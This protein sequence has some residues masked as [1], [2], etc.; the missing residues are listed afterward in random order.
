MFSLGLGFGKRF[1]SRAGL[2]FAALMCAMGP[3][4][5]GAQTAVNPASVT[6]P[7]T[8]VASV[9]APQIVTLTN[10]QATPLT[11]NAIAPSANFAVSGTTCPLSPNTLAA[12]LSCTISVTFS[13]V[14]TGY[15][16]GALTIT[17]DASN[18]PSTVPLS[19][20]GTSGG[21][22]SVTPGSLS[23]NATA[24]GQSFAASYV[25]FSNKQ[26]AAITVGPVQATGDFAVSNNTCP[27]SLSAAAS[28]KI[29]V[30]FTPTATGARAGTLSIADSVDT[31][32]VEVSLAGTG[33]APAT[34]APASLA[35]HS[36]V[37]SATS[38]VQYATVTNNQPGVLTI[39]QIAAPGGGF[40]VDSSACGSLP[41]S[42]APGHS[43]KIAVT[44][45]PAAIGNAAAT[46]GITES[47]T[48]TPLPVALS[49]TGVAAAAISPA[50]LNLGNVVTGTPSAIKTATL[51]NYQAVAMNIASIALPGGSAF[52]L[53]PSTTCPH[54][55]PLSAGASCTIAVTFTPPSTGAQSSTLTVTDD[56][57]NS[58]Q[59]LALSGAGILPATLS[60]SSVGFGSVAVGTT[61]AAKTVT[62]KNNSSSALSISSVLFGGPFALDASATSATTCPV[63]GGTLAAGATCVIGL[64]YSPVATGAN[65]GQITVIDSA[66]NSPQ[67]T[68]LTGTGV[69]AT[70][71]SP[72][73]VNF[74][75]VV[76][77][78]TSATKNV[79]LTNNQAVNLNLHTVAVT[80][81]YAVV[82]ATTTCMVG[83]PVGP[84]QS[85]TVSLNFTPTVLGGAPSSAL[86]IT[87][88]AATSPQ[89]VILTG[90]GASAVTLSPAPLNLGTV[91]VN[92]ATVKDVTLKNN[93]AVP[94]TIASITGFSGG[95]KLDSSS[96]CPLAPSALPAGASCVIAVSLTATATGANPGAITINDDAPGGSQSFNLSATSVAPVVVQ[97]PTLYF[98][99]QYLGTSSVASV[100]T[101][102]N[103][104]SVPLTISSVMVG[105]TNSGDFGVTT[106]CPLAP[107]SLPANSHCMLSV[108]FTPTGPGTRTAT[109]TIVD[110]APGSPRIV[111][112]T[113]PGSAPVVLSPTSITNFSAPV[114]TTSRYQTITVKNGDP[115]LPLHIS[116]FEF[117]GD[118]VQTSTTCPIGGGTALA[119]GASCNV[120]VSFAPSIGGVRTGQLQVNDDAV[121]SPQ[122][123]NLSGTGTSPLKLSTGAV[124]FSAQRVSTTSP[125]KTV[126]LTN[127]ESQQET[128]SLA[129]TGDFTASSNCTSG[130]IAAGSTCLLYVNFVPTATGPRYGSLTIAD[131]AAIGSPLT[132]S[133]S[134]SGT[135]TNPPGEVS[136]VSPGAGTAGTVVNAII[137]GNGWTN[138]GPTS[139]VSFDPP[140]GTIPSGITVTIPNPSTTT[141]NTINAQFTIAAGAIAGARNIRVVTGSKTALLV[142]AFIV[143]DTSNSHSIVTL[144]PSFG[145]Q[146]Q[147]LNVD[148]TAA[149]T[150]F[151]DGV[152]YA[153]FGDGITV[154]STTVTSPT[155]AQVNI[156]ISNT[157]FVGYRTVTLV[158]GGEFATSTPQGFLINPNSAALVSVA[159]NSAP[160]GTNLAV[161]LTASGTHFLQDAT[162]ASFGGGVLAGN[163]QVTSPTT[164]I[165]N[166]AVSSGAAVGLHDVQIATGGEMATLPN[167]FTVTGAT[168]YLAS[169]TPSSAQQGQTVTV[170]IKGVYTSF[171]ASNILADFGGD[172]TVNSTNVISPTEVQVKI[173][174]SQDAAVTGRTARLTSGPSGSATIFPF[175]FTVT[176]SAAQIVSVSPSNVAQGAQVTLNVVG[177]NTHWVQ[178]TTMAAFTPYPLGYIGVDEVTVT[179][180]THATLNIAVSTNHPVGE[181][182]FYMATGGEV[183]YASVS[184]Y[185]QTPTMT[186]SPAN[187]LPGASMSVS[188]TGQ[189]TNW[190]SNTLAVVG[191]QGVT[192]KNLVITSVASATGTLVIDPNA[193]PGSRT[194]TFTTGGEIDTTSFNVGSASLTNI[195]PSHAAQNTTLTVEITGS[196]TH[197]TS[198]VTVV[199]FDPFITVNGPPTVISPTDL[200]ANITVAANASAGWHTA[201]VNTGAEQLII[202]FLVDSPAMPMLV[203]V[204][205]ACGA[206][207]S[208]ESVTITGS[209]TNFVAGE[210]EAIL[211]AGVTV[212]D[213]NV[214]SPTV[215][216]ATISVSP[217][218]PIGGNSV[219]L[220]TGPEVISGTGFCVSPGAAEI[221]SVEPNVADI[222]AL[223]AGPFVVAQ[224]Q[225]AHLAF[226]GVGTHWLQGETI[227]D[228]GPGVHIDNLTVT[229]PTTA[230]VQ[231]TVLS[232]AQVGFAALTMTTDGEVVTLQQAIDIEQGYPTL[233]LTTPAGGEQGATLNLQLLGR[234]T[235]W[236]QGVTT[237]AF[238]QDI[239]V[240]S[241]TVIDSVSAIAN[242][243]VSPL[244]YID[245]VCSP[246]GH[247]IS[248]TTG[249]EQVSL[250]GTFCVSQGAAQVNQVSPSLAVQGSTQTVTITGSATHFIAGVTTA[251]F[252]PGINVGNVTVMS[253]TLATVSIAVT[254][255]APTGYTSVTLTTLGEV[256]T[257]QFAFQVS[258]GVATLNEAIPNQVEQGVQNVDVHLIGQY[259]HFSGLSTATFGEG[260]TV[261]SVSYTDAT[262]LTANVS[263][264][265]LSYTGS[266]TVTVTTPGVPCGDLFNVAATPPCAPGAT[267]GSEIVS[268]NA[269]TVIQGPAII[270]QVSPAGGNQGQ[271][272]V[273]Q[274]T[275]SNTHW[276]QNITQFYIPGAGSDL[277]I[278][279]VV[280]NSP[281]S[282]TVDL[283]ISPTAAPGARSIYMVTGGEALVDA[284]GFVLTGG[285]PAIAYLTPNKGQPGATTLDVTIHGIYTN[286]DSTSTVDFGPGITVATVQVEDST[287]INAVI[288]ISSGA[289]VGYRT[290]LVRTGAQGLT[291]NFLVYVPTPPVP[292][293]SYY[294]PSSGLT[295]Q[296]F[297]ISFT[298]SNTHWDPGPYNAATTATFGD[299]I[300]VNTFQVTS[301]TSALANITIDPSTYAGQRLIVFTTGAETES[302]TFNVSIPGVPGGAAPTLSIV[303]PSQGMQ[304]TASLNVNVIG[305]YTTF[306]NTTAFDFGQGITVNSVT[307]LGPTIASVNIS[308]DQLAQ[309]GG[310]SVTA[311]MGGQLVA[312]AGFSVTPS[313]ALISAIMP[314]TALQGSTITVEVTGQNTHWSSATTFQLGAG[315]VVASATVNSA[316]DATLVLSLPALAP[317]GPTYA[318]AQTLGEVANITH[319]FVVQAGTPLLLS[320]GP[321]S[322]PQQSSATF[323]I[324]SQATN[325]T[326]NPPTVD[327]GPG[328]TLTNTIVTGDTS[329]TVD[330]Y[331]Q[332][333]TTVGYRNLTVSTATQVLSLPNAV[334][335][336]AGPA[337]INTVSPST[338][339]Q[340][341]TVTVA[342]RGTNTHW[343]QGVTQLSFPGVVINSLTVTSATTA[344][345]SVTVSTSATPGLVNIITTT[346]LGEVATEVNAFEITQTQPEMLFIN[347]ASAML[348]QSETVTILTLNTHFGPTS[349]ASFGAGITVNSVAALTATSLQAN[350]TVQPTTVLGYR[351][352]SVTTGSEVV[353]STTLFQ[354]T[355][356]P[357]A[358]AS[359]S[360]ASGG[361]GRSVT[362]LVTG[363]QT[364]FASGVTS[365]SFGGGISVTGISVVDA[366]HANVTVSI[367]SSTPIASY[368]VTLTTGGEVATILGG[369]GVTLG[370]A[371]IATVTPAT[372]HQGDTNLSV[373]I[374]GQYTSF[375]NGSSSAS[376]GDGITVNSL[377]VSS[378]TTAVANI[379]ISPTA[380]LASRTVTVTTGPEV[381]SITG[382]FT[383]LAGLPRL[384]AV[385]PATGHQNDTNLSVSITGQFTNFVNGT[386][387]ANF[388]SG[389]TVNSLTVSSATAALANITI[390]PTATLASRT[391]T[392]TTGS[393]VAS[394]TSGFTV[395]AGLP[396]VSAVTPATGHQGDTSLS[397]SIT[398]QYTNFV[399]GTSAASFGSGITVNSFTVSSATSAVANITISDTAT[400]GLHTVTV[401]TGSE[402][403][404]NTGLFTVIVGL[405]TLAAVNPPTGNQGD[406]N[407]NVSI[408]GQFT[409]FVNGTSS[410]SFGAGITVN[411]LTVS[412][413]TAAVASITIS[414]TA[415][416]ASRTVTVTTG[417]EIAS[418]TGG[419]TVLAGTPSLVSA[420]PGSA[421]AGATTSVVIDGA[422][423]S[424]QQGVSTVSFGSGVTVNSVTVA[425]ATQLSVNVSVDP[426]AYTGA[427]D[428]TVT[429]D[430]QTVTLS[431][432][433]TVLPG[434]AV[435]T[436]INSNIGTPNSTV[437]VTINGQYTNW[438]SATTAS[439]G[440]GISVGGAAEGVSGPVTVNSA[441]SLTAT[442]NIDADADLGP[443]DVI[444]TTGTEIETV[445]AGFTVQPTTVSPPTVVSTS[446]GY[447]GT[448]PIN[449]SIYLVFS[450][451]MDRS[452]ITAANVLLYLNSS[453]GQYGNI[454]VAGSVSLD[455]AGRMLTFTPTS[456]L[457]VNTQYYFELT[458]GVKDASGN[459]LGYYYTYF[460]TA[461]STT[462]KPPTVIAANPP[463]SSPTVGTNTTIQ[464]QFSAP[465]DQ[466]TQT[467][468][469]LSDGSSN[470]AGTF[471][472]N[473][474]SNCSYN[475]AY[476]SYQCASG[477]IVTFTPA[478]PLTANH[479]YTVN[480]GAPL[481]DTA[482]NTLASGSFS[483][484]TGSGADTTNNS[485][486][487]PFSNYQPNMGTNFVPTVNFS[488]PIN[489]VDINSTTLNLYNID[490]GKYL[491][492]TVAVAPDGLSATFTPAMP[493]LP[494]TAYALQQSYGYYDMDGNYLYGAYSYFITGPGQELAPPQVSSIDPAN[495]AATVPLNAQVVVHYSEP[496]DPDNP[497]TLTLTSSGGTTIP[498][499]TT[500]AS[501][502]VT[503]TFVPSASLAGNTVYT[504]ALN[505]YKD[506]AGNA[507]A[508]FT[509]T[510]TTLSS[511]TPLTLSTGYTSGGTLNT[512][513][514]V[515]DANWVVAAG[516]S[517]PVAAEVIGSADSDFYPYQAANG[518]LSSWIAPNA[519]GNSGFNS[520]T[521]S[522]TFNLTGYSLTNLCLV[523]SEGVFPSG[524]LQLNGST[525]SQQ[526]SFDYYTLDPVNIALPASSLNAGANTLSFAANS[527]ESYYEAFR[528]QGS[529]QTC[530]AALTGGLSLVS[531][532]PAGNATNVAT[533]STITLNFNNPLDPATVSSNTLRV[534]NGYNGN[535]QIAGTY[536]VTGSQVVFTP[537]GPLPVNANIYVTAYGGPTDVAGD[538]YPGNYTNLF[539]F[540]TSGSGTPAA[541]PFQV[542]A[543]SPVAGTT[544]VGLRAPVVATFN[545]SF[546]PN[547][548]NQSNAASDFALYAGDNL[549]CTS[550]MKSQ[551]NTT[552]Q[553]NCYPLPASTTMTAFVNSN[554]QDMSGNAVANF[555]SQ[556]S[557]SAADSSTQG[558]VVSSRPGNGASAIGVN[559]PLLLFT[560]LPV[561]AS[562]ASAG[563]QVAQ[564]GAAI[565]G[566]VQVLD[567]GY[568]IEFTPSAPFAPGSLIQWFTTTSLIDATY[569]NGFTTTS[570]YFNIAG[571]TST[572]PPTIQVSS[573]AL[574]SY[575]T[576]ALNSIVDLQFNTP[577]DASTVNSSN[578][579]LYDSHTGL[580]VPATY[581]MP[582]PNAVRMAPQADLSPNAYIYIYVTTGLH[583]ST[584]VPAAAVAPYFY[585][586][587][588]DDT[589]VP[590]ATNAVPY[591]G[592]SNI[593]VNVTPGVVFSKAIDPVSINSTTFQV[594]NGGTPL[595]GGFLISSDDTRVEF[596]PNAPLPASATLTMKLTGVLDPEAHP[597]NYS[598]HFQTA[599]GPDFNRPTVVNTNV[600][601]NSTIPTNST[602]TIQFSESM[603]ITTFNTTN[604]YV[605]DNLLN[606][607]IAATLSWSAD[608]SVA[609]LVPSS[610]LAAGRSYY[611]YVYGGTDL[612]GNSLQGYN[613]V[614]FTAAFASTAIA[615]TVQYFNP[616]RGAIGLGLNAVIEAQFTGAIDPTT[617]GGVTV[618][619]GGTPVAASPSVSAGNTVV[620]LTPATPLLPNTLYQVTIAGVKDPAG[621]TVATVTSSFTTGATYDLAAPTLVTYDP[622]NNSTVG[623]NVIP[624]LVFNKPL[625][626]LTVS[627][628]TFTM[629]LSDTGQFIPLTVTPSANGLTVTLQP[630]IALLPNTNYSYRGSNYQDADG[631]SG[632]YFYLYFTTGNGSDT[633]GP[634]VKVS[635][636]AGSTGIPLNAQVVATVFKP[637]D[638]TSWSQSSIQLSD[639]H[640]NSISGAVSQNAPNALTFVPAGNLS[641]NVTYTVKVSG[642]TDADG[643]AVVATNTT[644]TTGAT[645]AT[646]GLT[647]VSSNVA[648]GSANVSSTQ[649]IVLTFS[650]ILDPT[651]VNDNTLK[652]MNG[653]NSNLGIAGTYSVSGNQVTFTPT[654]PY[655]AGAQ[656]YVGE[657]NG[658][659]D[660]LGEVFLNG[661]CY[662]QQLIYFTVSTATPDTTPLTVVSVNPAAAATGLRLDIP[663]SVTFNKSINP[664]SVYGSNI[665]NA[666]LY[667]GQSLQDSGSVS[668]SAD[669]RT[670]TFNVG[671]L[672]GG[673][674]YTIDL[675]AGGITDMSGNAL[676]KLFTSSFSTT[677]DPVTGSSSVTSVE[678][679]YN[680]T[681]VPTDSLITAF[682]NRPVDPS[683]VPGTSAV[684]VNGQVYSGT[685]QVIGGGY[686][687]QYTPTVPF[688]AGAV[689]QWFLTGISDTS[690]NPINN[691]S[692]NFYIAAAPDPTAAPRLVNPSP[693]YGSNNVPVNTLFDFQY[694]LPIDASTLS[695]ATFVS[696]YGQS[697]PAYSVTLP[698]PTVVR[699]TPA[700]ALAPSTTYYM[701]LTGSFNGT[702]GVAAQNGC[703]YFTTTST[704][705]DTTSGTVK[706]APPN[707]SVNIGTNGSIRVVFSKP[708]DPTSVNASTI[709]VTTGG[710]AVPGSLS[711]NSSGN[712]YL[713]ASF[714]PVNPLPAS[715]TIQAGVNGVLD[716]GGNSFA[717]ATTKF[718]TGPGPDF[719]T[720]AVS[721]D[722][723]YGATGIATNASFSCRY[724]KPIDP[725]SITPSGVRLYSY[726]TSAY[727][728]VG[729]TFSSDMMSVTMTPTSALTPNTQYSYS[730]YNAIDLTGNAAQNSYR[731]FTTGSGPS[732]SGPTLLY[733]NPPNGATNVAL[734]TNQGAFNSTSL[735]LLFSEPLAENSLAN[736]TL[737]PVGGSPLAIGLSQ[738]IGDTEV[739]VTLP[740]TLQPNTTYTYSISGVTDY[741]GNAITPVTS[742]FTTGSGFDYTAPTIN[743]VVPANNATNVAL[744]TPL[745][746]TFSEPMNPILFTGSQVYLRDHNSQ[747]VIPTTFTLST[748]FAT[749]SLA[750]VSPLTA[751]TIYDIVVQPSNWYLADFAGNSLYYYSTVS[752][753]TTSP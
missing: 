176:A 99:A 621:N 365:A 632:S 396:T 118:F 736:I 363:S 69:A 192:L 234:F 36:V 76:V 245:Y 30:T 110:D 173:T 667:A 412:S 413:A 541:A 659:T 643:N 235:H 613:Y 156:T 585:S 366:H 256:A 636:A 400:L 315:I 534:L 122:V 143:A 375:V 381:A 742:T 371:K 402:V 248:I 150:N 166:I 342:L 34:I 68:R 441:T 448:V 123:V 161:T 688:P 560:S 443:R 228:F 116:G 532:T 67:F 751:G 308:I 229:S 104:Q 750:P 592:A 198:N 232:S 79:T 247:T 631:N 519:S 468:L 526:L 460:N 172:V 512:S 724:S 42:V 717:K 616:L 377:I 354:V 11:I 581:T 456:A 669:N 478:S 692:G 630:Q 513:G 445:P 734:D 170:D 72:A 103:E 86:T 362:V 311:T 605:Y 268:A 288:N 548:I 475:Y 50:S 85:C 691:A 213:L 596:V 498:G 611:L 725:G 25:T 556:F 285:I 683:T 624:K 174:V 66:G 290:V 181:H 568:T 410:A 39:T 728:S 63:A 225:T 280:I 539:S 190:A 327:F 115:A 387:S 679:N 175:S 524:Y 284:G 97:F 80:G 128:F 713:G 26:S 90:T 151:V 439:F 733:A 137:T 651:T 238:N 485:A 8:P 603:D 752:T 738:N 163:V 384:S 55:G 467:G 82:P 276:A 444:V 505:G 748:D 350:I 746:V 349:T 211:G 346:T 535:E 142:A 474:G 255:A 622:P 330:G 226:V 573:P 702:N 74:N 22:T 194:I 574:Y 177:L 4:L 521:Y 612:A 563:L 414:P 35:F 440:P 522:T 425:N 423:T 455:A 462:T 490:S 260:V 628:A 334:Y 2:L 186:V 415:T 564:N 553:F 239:T 719:T 333:T 558:T 481:A 273:F 144:S 732:T 81:P 243:T 168:P 393:E 729:Y 96:T 482:G 711:L 658:P 135:S 222:T 16:S 594:T 201:Y 379:T 62:L 353:A 146:G 294:V 598:S 279:A 525:I 502:Q 65:S 686:E 200:T 567:N 653:W 340:G 610:L 515:P 335:V 108:T 300:A 655:P 397:V 43:C 287:T 48:P 98:K 678:P 331:V 216:T 601:D 18:S 140:S 378:V 14:E 569:G 53:D 484:T 694:T 641:P 178:G 148:I 73:T 552:L 191:G 542:T 204:N 709:A 254:T 689:V 277:T 131:S 422:F 91:V 710:N 154:N 547:T 559:S 749:I 407:L 438:G 426:N 101:I 718:T 56:A 582:Q 83:T 740:Y 237:A 246:S 424:F 599:A 507:G 583:S 184:V 27:A 435:I 662:G 316:T 520:Y 47:A 275:G 427:R 19:G 451:P 369:F 645:A 329:L 480:Y 404:S 464:L 509:S 214:T 476:S 508:A 278:N 1:A 209:L 446:P 324:L 577:L 586:G 321:G 206:Q 251:S 433:F 668:F 546:N 127:K 499:T 149:G 37:V 469:T 707:G 566:T 264:D 576:P 49:G 373:S 431:G 28:C 409:N 517:A 575:Y 271:D 70:T 160:Q 557:T 295:G 240:N 385:S 656:I 471:G 580:N 697:F 671:A 727:V 162:T 171:D 355:Q 745:S 59:T 244:A 695:G 21:A 543:F 15:A 368:D 714:Y 9:S 712:D 743:T 449:T 405:P 185:A 620:Q 5:A 701:C 493:L 530:G 571:D 399:N 125:P 249:S 138:F 383:V 390:S 286:W 506:F 565:S 625:N 696:E 117:N 615:P 572:L 303:D 454:P 58:P 465:M 633:S 164:A 721:L 635:P 145:T 699:V 106:N 501:D 687:V 233:L 203:S 650:Q 88:D 261:N 652:V 84:G 551:D 31:N 297:T 323:T 210:T 224:L 301:P 351:S 389:I 720:A 531:S 328:I 24:I 617:V 527:N 436:Q 183:V 199:N 579:Y 401:T 95:Y 352:V 466:A 112:L 602:F 339:G 262:D 418:I 314:N 307:V 197:F 61:I 673:T 597:V 358:I 370:N 672:T 195:T 281:T 274:I 533:N 731:Y 218:A 477:T 518:P 562:T 120:T 544:N 591:N 40:L 376:F 343:Q 570:G 119:G 51:T 491:R 147:T 289:A 45:S 452:T 626:P 627:N 364:N 299:G 735:G 129:V 514:D 338:G 188:F 33:L 723:S 41:I 189:F 421:Q 292:A 458:N 634:E 685:T 698:S 252:G 680:A 223:P 57:G 313:L 406:T 516:S 463:A 374:T 77:G 102:T 660:V 111:A 159:P 629:Y 618:T 488:K 681:G 388:G 180:A 263:V 690:G 382:G 461:F 357:A 619:T 510:F 259:S 208:T 693:A 657:C 704:G 523:G 17:D 391:V 348:G 367:P 593:G 167:A 661:S 236:Q 700:T 52:A 682:V 372:G 141:A 408:T 60:P 588:A 644:F 215:A 155:T 3:A 670:I 187:G 403:A 741:T 12:H 345:A 503:L 139:V 100:D 665:G 614:N 447:Y 231:I 677:T 326:T 417:A 708:V 726:A 291:G 283:S 416:L 442:L 638:P 479:A 121:T 193:T 555:S 44:F 318:S 429:T 212:A 584:S 675:P 529:V 336:S 705:A 500:L 595:A 105:G 20:T 322:V 132:V 78:A 89:S 604:F 430:T 494:D 6:F 304:G 528:F 453:P 153:N 179:D 419:F 257:Q 606:T 428:I 319:G 640:G 126:I 706:I 647:L 703:T 483:F 590:T 486:S 130:V 305:Q 320:S 114:G 332:P 317:I 587:T 716:Y 219:I 253:P 265:P 649:A 309:L 306:D 380:T 722:F 663:V 29:Y 637:I 664:S 182:S 578:I 207:G 549:N 282:A 54:P 607:R 432:G 504:V 134:G 646:G 497:G 205:P 312:G 495:T 654:S 459:S 157:T 470:V 420:T 537:A 46:L 242:I 715:S 158:T 511:V 272:V 648:V 152:T 64:V 666:L 337:V 737:T 196:N 296:T 71:L 220:I 227:A 492:G 109:L 32:P 395:L 266:R 398:G 536:Q 361:Q 739:A 165:A 623:T 360:P 684:T 496:I 7:G 258:P 550:Y 386:S 92:S 93:Q 747:V 230:N 600:T 124:T 270:T 344:T 540:T 450:Q 298:G 267:T 473:S 489:P 487:V 269:L 133:L 674:V 107:S 38:A 411:S 221:V 608:Q 642:F 554:L 217:T 23:F 434:T 676:A 744:S 394:I 310:R 293:I 753:F 392:V 457:A 347:S 325:W 10:S 341:A 169:V 730:C 136:V 241:L 545:R 94:L 472:W 538:T 437:T 250:P 609:Y 561:N 589:T 75:G 356:G 113:G 359:L 302:A 13:P 639:N 87:D 202:G